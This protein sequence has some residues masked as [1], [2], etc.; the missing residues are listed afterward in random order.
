MWPFNRSDSS[1]PARINA[2]DLD[3]MLSDSSSPFLL[4]VREPF[5]LTAFGSIP[6]VVNIPLGDLPSQL[7]RLPAELDRPIVVVCQRG[8]RS[9]S[10]AR[11]LIQKGYTNVYNLDGGT[12]GW[13]QR[14]RERARA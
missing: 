5:E 9:L 12:L 6:G 11:T 7:T 13:L 3:R 1:T 4:D 10:A 8:S 2:G 14:E